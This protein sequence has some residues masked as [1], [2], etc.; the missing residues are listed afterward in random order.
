MLKKI[1]AFT[2]FLGFCIYLNAQSKSLSPFHAIKAATGL[3]VQLVKGDAPK[4]EYTILKGNA[5]DLYIEVENGELIVKL[6]S[7]NGKWNRSETKANI[8]I[9]YTNLNAIDCSSGAYVYTDQAITSDKMEI[10]TSSGSKCKIILQCNEVIANSSSGSSMTL[11]GKSKTATF[12]A[13]SGSKI[14]ASS[15][16]VNIAEADVSSGANISLNAAKKLKADAS[17]GG[18][19]K[20]KGKPDDVNINSGMS[21]SISSF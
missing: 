13:S 8:T 12:D 15:L 6:K 20:Y 1:F 19:I 14:S 11:E 18:S 4:A 5:E 21:G 10:E 3:N 7:K 2:L 16:E 9:Y 17:S